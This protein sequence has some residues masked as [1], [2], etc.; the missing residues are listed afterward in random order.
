MGAVRGA[1]GGGEGAKGFK[2]YKRDA[3]PYVVEIARYDWPDADRNRK[4]PVKLYFPKTGPGPFPIVLFTPGFASREDYEFLGRHW[5]SH[6]Y[7]AVHLQHPGS[8]QAVLR[9]PDVKAAAA[10]AVKPQHGLD[11]ILDV[12]F[13]LDR[14]TA[15]DHDAGS[16]LRDRLNLREVGIAGHSYGA[17]TTLAVAGQK[18]PQWD[19]GR[20]TFADPRIKAAITMSAPPVKPNPPAK[21]FEMVKTPM[22]HMTGIRGGGPVDGSQVAERRAVFDS[23]TNADQY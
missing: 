22:L 17:G 5:A 10:E 11:R 6:G 3:G 16:P 4:L 2:P 18:F 1:V 21:L 9:A 20:S 13:A 12:Y 19:E 7:V 8:D 14:L 23:V 15:L